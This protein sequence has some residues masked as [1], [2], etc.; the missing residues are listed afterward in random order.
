[1]IFEELQIVKVVQEDDRQ[2]DTYY[3]QHL[4]WKD[5]FENKDQMLAQKMENM[6]ECLVCN[7]GIYYLVGNMGIEKTYEWWHH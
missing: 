2:K 3:F 4:Q 6:E 1:M 7:M 5:N